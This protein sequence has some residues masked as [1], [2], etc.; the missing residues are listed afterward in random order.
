M[1]ELEVQL[2]NGYRSL[3]EKKKRSAGSTQKISET[4]SNEYN[5]GVQECKQNNTGHIKFK[6]ANDTAYGYIHSYVSSKYI[7]KHSGKVKHQ[8]QINFP[9]ETREYRE[10]PLF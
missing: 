7:K 2:L 5:Q 1:D 8:I 9:Q 4:M 10:I 3:H 6:E